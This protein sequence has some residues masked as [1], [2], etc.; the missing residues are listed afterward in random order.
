VIANTSATVTSPSRSNRQ[1][2]TR[3][4]PF[5]L[6]P[7]TYPEALVGNS[8]YG[9]KRQALIENREHLTTQQDNAAASYYS[10]ALAISLLTAAYLIWFCRVRLLWNDELLAMQYDQLPTFAASWNAILH[11][12]TVF[13][14]PTYHLLSELAMRL[15]GVNAL[16]LRLPSLIGLVLMQWALFA[17]VKRIAGFR[18]A[19]I[20]MLLPVGLST[21][22]W[23]SDGRPYGLMLGLHMLVILFWYI[24]TR[25]IDERCQGK[26]MYLA[27]AGLFVALFLS[28]TNHYYGFLIFAPVITGE[29]ARLM[30]RRHIDWKILSVMALTA[31]AFLIDYIFSKG[32]APF[33][34]GYVV[35]KLSLAEFG[36]LYIDLFV[37]NDRWS[38][39]SEI[40]A[41]LSF[42]LLFVIFVTM[43]V[44][45]LRHDT[46]ADPSLL[47]LMIAVL[48]LA[49]LPVFG[50]VT[51][52]FAK[53]DFQMR[54]TLTAS[55]AWFIVTGFL[56]KP[57]L[58]SSRRWF[59]VFF[60]LLTAVISIA[61]L[62]LRNTR[63][64]ATL[65][66]KE[67]VLPAA[68]A[69]DLIHHPEEHI[70]IADSNYFLT[71]NYYLGDQNLRNRVTFLYD[72]EKERRWLQSDQLNL[73]ANQFKKFTNLHVSSFDEMVKQKSPFV[74]IYDDGFD[75][76]SM[77][78][79]QNNTPV[80]YLGS[81]LEG[82]LYRM[83]ASPPADQ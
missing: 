52:W 38:S 54:Y 49:L 50:L 16:A 8:S 9:G 36:R 29:L 3:L 70:F 19:I 69:A 23:G 62:H 27:L 14:P 63:R 71:A 13:E 10:L 79:K 51:N 65:Q 18:S 4:R 6:A 11:Y 68:I 55:L 39:R 37:N 78:V 1:L 64:V 43:I 44:R 66:L 57:L 61:G 80:Q 60:I 24:A 12:P 5:Q 22:R 17:L 30:I 32:V 41:S 25:N 28:V 31:P 83:Q 82:E 56:I 15:L 67:L 81:A 2:N 59:V 72:S 7:T 75:W 26:N 34:A 46:R 53:G 42:L 48:T 73:D 77:D 40:L 21:L 33:R 35:H 20:V 76:L 45:I 58:V 47:P 74:V